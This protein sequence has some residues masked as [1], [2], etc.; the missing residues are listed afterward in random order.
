MDTNEKM[1]QPTGAVQPSADV[2]S[3][4][5][6][7][8][9]T[10]SD[11]VCEGHG[12]DGAV[13]GDAGQSGNE[14]C[15]QETPA[16]EQPDG[17]Q[18]ADNRPAEA[19][20]TEGQAPRR[21]VRTLLFAGAILLLCCIAAAVWIYR[22]NR[23]GAAVP[24][25]AATAPTT[26]SA[27]TGDGGQRALTGT[28]ALLADYFEENYN[29]DYA[30]AI[31]ADLTHDGEN[32]LIV[33]DSMD[34]AFTDYPALHGETIE[35]ERMLESPNRTCVLHVD[36]EGAVIELYQFGVENWAGAQGGLY[37]YRQDGRDYL[38]TYQPTVWQGACEYRYALFSLSP[39][40]EPLPLADGEWTR[41]FDTA[42][43]AE[44]YLFSEAFLEDPVYQ[45]FEKEIAA[46]LKEA[47]PIVAYYTVYDAATRHDWVTEFAYL[48]EVLTQF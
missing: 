25:A 12:P 1:E 21:G 32:E 34:P 42:D 33:F 16:A 30:S 23:L 5:V 8:D 22:K 13:P 10:P 44:E 40:G 19:Q 45:A 24:G 36:A 4:A 38:L 26:T 27:Q 46:Y 47:K 43:A 35:P 48:D 31:F 18:P 7:D 3:D 17:K 15:D 29:V 9:I 37:L 39:D 2:A 20:T 28:D 6:Q 11:A 41:S 14:P